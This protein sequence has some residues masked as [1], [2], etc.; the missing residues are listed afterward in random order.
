MWAVSASVM[1]A[2][3]PAQA[4]PAALLVPPSDAPQAQAETAADS[5]IL[6]VPESMAAAIRF[7]ADIF[8]RYDSDSVLLHDREDLG[9]VWR[10]VSLP[11][12]ADGTIDP[13]RANEKIGEASEALS[14][15]LE[16]LERTG[17]PQ[18]H[19][20]QLLWAI[21]DG[22]EARLAGASQRVR[23][24]RGIAGSFRLGLERSKK[25]LP[26]VVTILAA[27]GVPTELKALP[28]I[29]STFNPLARSSAGA[30]GLWQLMPATARQLGLRVSRKVDERLD[31]L[32][33]TR[34]A[35]KMLKQNHR[36]LGNWPLAITGY[37]HG[38]NGIR[39][40]VKAVGSDDITVLI[41]KYS[42][43]TWGFASKNFYPEFLA[44]LGLVEKME[45]EGLA[46]N[47]AGAA[48]EES[49]LVV[50]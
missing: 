10:V 42:K 47:E 41:A 46:H 39:R 38:P 31:V 7:W 50:D 26:E 9:I 37:N 12:E 28:F 8:S 1:L 21:I 22:D 16:Q 36:M 49:T 17:Q 27:E 35:A 14:K 4:S 19:D 15:R 24:Q 33:S 30:A 23:A 5:A 43:R 40:A 48:G 11:V 44:A 6:P 34:A 13:A 3:A 2:G 29:E 18:D 45:R 20:D 32:R 25:W